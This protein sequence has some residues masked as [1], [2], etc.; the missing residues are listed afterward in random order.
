LTGN[1]LA[2]LLNPSEIELSDLDDV[3]SNLEDG[4]VEEKVARVKT[5]VLEEKKAP[6]KKAVKA[7]K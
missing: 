5:P 6:K 4:E 3:L 1:K 2:P 7:K